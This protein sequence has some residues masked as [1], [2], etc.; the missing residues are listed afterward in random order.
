MSVR[1]RS[2]LAYGAVSV[3]LHVAAFGTARYRSTTL[4]PNPATTPPVSGE[5][6]DIQ[7]PATPE[8]DLASENTGPS[9][10]PASQPANDVGQLVR[11]SSAPRNPASR[12]GEARHEL[13]G[14]I[15]TRFATDLSATLTRAIPQAFSADRAWTD[16]AFGDAGVADLTLVLDEAGHLATSSV[17]GRPSSALRSSIER[18]L[19]L[20]AARSFTAR[21]ARTRLR[22]SARVTLD[23]LHDGLHGDVFAL[24][25]GSFAGTDGSAFFALPA[26]A[27]PG[28]RV[29]VQVRE[30]R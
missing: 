14:A 17:A 15:G 25:G 18:T 4:L 3:A 16:A 1:A 22:L 10:P 26:R 2:V 7:T 9:D 28:R 11:A 30:L 8:I 5:T 29:D 23:D 21:Q 24:S 12:S 27:G 13:F 20:L 6:F 19:A